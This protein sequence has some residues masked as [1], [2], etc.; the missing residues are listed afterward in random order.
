MDIKMKIKL[1]MGILLPVF[2]GPLPAQGNLTEALPNESSAKQSEKN[3]KI[4]VTIDGGS[5]T[6]KSPIAKGL[7][8]KFNLLYL[9]T[10]AIYRT[11]AHVL[12]KHK[13]EAQEENKQKIEEFLKNVPWKIS[14]KN[15][16]ACFIIDGEILSDRELRSEMLNATVA[17]YAHLFE[18]IHNF[19]LK[20]A[21]TTL[22]Y[23]ESEG[24]AGVV[25]EGRTCGTQCFPK[26]DLKFWFNASPEAKIA[27]RSVEEKE[28]DDPLKR[29]ILDKTNPF[30]PLKEP[31]NAI[32][33][34]TNNRPI[35]ENIQLTSAFVEQ[36]RDEKNELFKLEKINSL[37]IPP[38]STAQWW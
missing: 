17:V 20:L 15:R 19:C 25:A 23:I 37:Q 2:I 7:S 22:D 29:D 36:K 28:I 14:I 18:S 27:F 38:N 34:W 26:A 35:P 21:R 32:R 3:T 1:V 8:E 13:L 5:A 9:E 11:I 4:L 31:E 10:G 33:I 6:K 24:L 12:A 16:Y 30:S